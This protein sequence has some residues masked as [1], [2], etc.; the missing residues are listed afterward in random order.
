MMPKQSPRRLIKVMIVD[1]EERVRRLARHLLESDR[2]LRIVAEADNGQAAAALAREY[3]PD[4]VLMDI[5][6]PVMNGLDAARAILRECPQIRIIMTSAMGAD[7]YRR[8]SLSL[9][10]SK[11]I[12]KAD[13]DTSLVTAVRE[14]NAATFKFG[15]H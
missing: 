7:P 5:S 4:V 14:V 10:A 8:V 3:L 9:G 13:L 11:F 15:P 6:M 1:D 2:E 12:D